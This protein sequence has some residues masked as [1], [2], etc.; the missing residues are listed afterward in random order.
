MDVKSPL[1][2]KHLWGAAA[3]VFGKENEAWK[4]E[5]RVLDTVDSPRQPK[6]IPYSP[7]KSKTVPDGPKESQAVPESPTESSRK[8][9]TVQ[10][11]PTERVQNYSGCKFMQSASKYKVQNFARFQFNACLVLRLLH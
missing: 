5:K 2:G 3:D 9:R 1:A 11:S 8:S 7:K 10:E 4:K 6:R